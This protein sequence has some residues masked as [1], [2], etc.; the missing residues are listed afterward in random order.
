MGYAGGSKHGFFI[1]LKK[2]VLAIQNDK[3]KATKQKKR[4]PTPKKSSNTISLVLTKELHE[5]LNAKALK[6]EFKSTKG[7]YSLYDHIIGLGAQPNSVDDLVIAMSIAYSWMPTMLD[8]YAS[9]KK[10]LK[11]LLPV[12]RKLGAIKNIEQFEKQEGSIEEWLVALVQAIN[13]SVVGVSKTLHIFFPKTI[14]IIDSRLLKA[15]TN[16]FAGHYKKEP[17]LK[18]PSTVPQNSQ[19]FVRVYMQ[20]WKLLLYWDKNIGSKDMR[21]LEKPLYWIGKS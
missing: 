21:K 3:P 8:V 14:P 7:K 20:Y 19:R 17:Q 13:H 18:L 9:D 10:A 6:M 16:I 15:W 1:Q 11:K 5:R 4:K 2:K 12:I